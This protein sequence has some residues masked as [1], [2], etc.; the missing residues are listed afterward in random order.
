LESS[1]AKEKKM[2]NA[3]IAT[4]N[5]QL[6]KNKEFLKDNQLAVGTEEKHVRDLA[7]IIDSYEENIVR[8]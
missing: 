7:K 2:L 3:K 8:E 5:Y 6:S 4:L 1:D